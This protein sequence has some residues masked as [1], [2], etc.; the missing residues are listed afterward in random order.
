MVVRR[1][2]DFYVMPVEAMLL[3]CLADLPIVDVLDGLRKK[4][5]VSKR[6]L[7]PFANLLFAEVFPFAIV[8]N[9][10]QA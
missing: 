8:P 2:F 7:Q 1:P 6:K 9:V 5:M 4:R 3:S 10:S